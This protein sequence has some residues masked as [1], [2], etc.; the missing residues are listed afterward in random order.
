MQN[1]A[2]N[3]QDSSFR[4]MK[5]LSVMEVKTD[6]ELHEELHFVTDGLPDKLKSDYEQELRQ[7]MKRRG[8]TA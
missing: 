8:L 5:H 6:D 7:E 3:W 4:P 2:D 1:K